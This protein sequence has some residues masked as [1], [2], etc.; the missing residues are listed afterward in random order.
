MIVKQSFE[1]C[2][3][4]LDRADPPPAVGLHQEIG[5]LHAMVGI[6]PEEDEFGPKR[7]LQ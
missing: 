6:G 7:R 3:Q 4:V 1:L 5:Y 2:R